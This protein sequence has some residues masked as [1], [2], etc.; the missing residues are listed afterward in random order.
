MDFPAAPSRGRLLGLAMLAVSVA[1]EIGLV[2]LMW[3]VGPG[4]VAALLV[5]VVFLLVPLVGRLTYWVWGCLN[6]RYT[7]GRDGI[8]IRWAASTQI[9]PMA[10]ITHVLGGR[11]YGGSLEGFHW[12]GYEVGHTRV[13]TDDGAI[14]PMLAYSTMPPSGQLV[15]VTNDLAYAISPANRPSFINEFR[16]R[17][18]LGPVQDLRQETA[19]ARWAGLSLWRDG[20]ALRLIG[21]AVVLVVLALAWLMWH[22]PSLPAQVILQA[23]YN[24]GQGQK[25]TDLLRPRILVWTLPLIGLATVVTNLVIAA[26]VHQRARLAAV[27]LASGAVLVALALWVVV[28]RVAA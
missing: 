7:L 20:L 6:L 1:A 2:A 27:L 19:Q 18:R 9:I 22:Y 23:Q 17:R 28:I 21:V 3:R 10:A 5:L 12:P 26:V 15:I 25:A 8:A 14:R 13:A 11:P 4:P 16:L 24:P